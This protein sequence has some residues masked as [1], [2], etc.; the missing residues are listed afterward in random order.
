MAGKGDSPKNCFSKQFKDNY[1]QINWGHKTPWDKFSDE[2][3][4]KHP[5]LCDA[6]PPNCEYC[7]HVY[8]DCPNHFGIN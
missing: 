2:M 6:L 3:A 7:G 8:C 5:E 1:D 4:E